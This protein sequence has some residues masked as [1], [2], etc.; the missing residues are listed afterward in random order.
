M[1][2]YKKEDREMFW[3]ECLHPP[4]IHIWNSNPSHDGIWRW[5]LWE[6]S[7]SWEW[8]SHDGI[9]TLIRGDTRELAYSFF[10]LHVRIQWE[11]NQ[12]QTR[13]WALLRKPDLLAP[14]SWTSQ[15]VRKNKCL[16]CKPLSLWYF[17]Y[18][19]LNRLRQGWC[20]L[21]LYWLFFKKHCL[22]LIIIIC[23]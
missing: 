8:S 14:W 1:G 13:K 23:V 18:R 12:L 7:R 15:T 11:H 6:V 4:Q 17:C 20:S 22:K 21:H 3:F 2:H 10:P 16:L 9:N 5:G 19:T